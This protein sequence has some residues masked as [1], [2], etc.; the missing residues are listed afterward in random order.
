MINPAEA[1]FI[2]DHAHIPE[3]LPGYGSIMSGGEPF[4]VEDFVAYHGRGALV[5][6]GYPLEEKINEDRLARTLTATIQRL[7]PNQAVLIAPS[8]PSLEGT[9]GKADVYYRLDLTHVQIRSKVNN[10]ILRA[11]REVKVEM[12]RSLGAEHERLI[13][14]FLESSNLE[15]GSRFIFKKIPEY[16]SSVSTAEIFSARD[17]SGNIAAF[18]IADFGSKQYVFYMFNFRSRVR[19]IPGVSDLLIHALIQEAKAQGKIAV[20]MGLGINEGVAFFKKKWGACPFLNHE[21]LCLPAKRPSFFESIFQGLIK[22]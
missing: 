9:R 8:I 17:A 14:D 2:Q 6:I 4:L 21:S 22:G 19:I 7:N 11:G 10:M 5:F 20:N 1:S 15:E 16:I 12:G 3:H 13:A 18:D